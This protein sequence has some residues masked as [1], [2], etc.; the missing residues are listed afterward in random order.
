MDDVIINKIAIM[1]KCIRRIHEEYDGHEDELLYNYTKQDSV[2][3]NLQRACEAAI[4]LGTRVVRLKKLGIPQRTRDV[5]SFL[6]TNQ[7]IS[8]KLAQA[9]QSM[10]GFRNIA[11][12]G[13]QKVNLDIVHAIIRNNLSDFE[14]YIQEMKKN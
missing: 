6:S 9:L 11:V 4:D 7:I 8:E 1:E 2:I 12:H 14:Q 3:L 5:F 13:Y 10:V